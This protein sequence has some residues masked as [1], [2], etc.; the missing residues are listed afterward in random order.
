MLSVFML[1]CAVLGCKLVI[2]MDEL[3]W[4]LTDAQLSAAVL[5]V[6]SLSHLIEQDTLTNQRVKVIILE[7][8]HLIDNETNRK[9]KMNRP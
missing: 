1:L 4:V 8:P 9:Q 7:T 3:L 6:Q 2:I 5:F